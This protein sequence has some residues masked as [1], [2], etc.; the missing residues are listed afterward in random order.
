MAALMT[1]SPCATDQ[2]LDHHAPN[3][4]PKAN[5]KPVSQS[6]APLNA[7]NPNAPIE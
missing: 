3:E 7:N 5:T 6:T 4:L 1:P 2:R